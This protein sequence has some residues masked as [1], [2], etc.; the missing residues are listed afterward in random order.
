M[1]KEQPNNIMQQHIEKIVLGV[2]VLALVIS[3]AVYGVGSSGTVQLGGRDVPLAEAD[4]A[5]LT[6]AQQR[7]QQAEQADIELPPVKTFRGQIRQAQNEPLPDDMLEQWPNTA[8]SGGMEYLPAGPEFAAFP[9]VEPYVPAGGAEGAEEITLAQVQAQLLRP[10]LHGVKAARELRNL[11]ED[12]R[13]R[14]EATV[15]HGVGSYAIADTLDVWKRDLAKRGIP[16]RF[17]VVG[18]RIER[19]RMNL[20]GTWGEPEPVTPVVQLDRGLMPQPDYKDAVPKY[21]GTAGGRQEVRRAME[22]I[23]L[24]LDQIR[25]EPE[26]PDERPE[27]KW[28]VTGPNEALNRL[29][30]ILQPPYVQ[31]IYIPARGEWGPWQV[32]LPK[33]PISKAEQSRLDAEMDEDGQRERPGRRPSPRRP[34]S[35]PP[36]PYS[37]RRPYAPGLQAPPRRRPGPFEGGPP[38]YG[39]EYRPPRR[40]SGGETRP[41]RERDPDRQEEEL[42][43]L[44]V[45]AV[46]P[47][48]QQLFDGRVLVWWH[49][50]RDLQPGATYRYR[51][52]LVVTNPLL[53][54][55]EPGQVKDAADAKERFLETRWS[56]WSVSVRAP[57][58]ADLFVT[59]RVNM[60]LNG[61][62]LRK[63]YI[64]VFRQVRGQTL[65]EQFDVSEGE[66]I[67]GTRSREFFDPLVGER[68]TR[69]IDFATGDVVIDLDFKTVEVRGT[70]RPSV[71]VTY[72]DAQGRM[73]RA[74]LVDVLPPDSRRRKLYEKREAEAKRAAEAVAPPE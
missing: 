35:P 55:D 26:D 51:Y 45:T 69:N 38:G 57:E 47:M 65:K 23:S 28:I 56:D 71:D 13:R 37:P 22:Q 59:G 61:E 5:V 6:A 49:D 72:V 33:N 58:L 62:R 7:E 31:D 64:M 70:D 67:G 10:R 17:A 9:D 34:Y 73:Q 25:I 30:S 48:D 50:T 14:P 24:E 41:P 4:E 2:C 15:V 44:D 21:D 1:A 8:L 63:A 12:S 46:P 18:V 68:V 36:R 27:T 29:L 54:Y 19:S 39:D 52:R 40:P 43:P 16:A 32:N 66:L 20:D 60:E 74:S 53:S 3:F 11:P 42:P